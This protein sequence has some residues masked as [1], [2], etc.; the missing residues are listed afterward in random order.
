VTDSIPDA[1]ALETWHGIASRWPGETHS[2]HAISGTTTIATSGGDLAPSPIASLSKLLSSY[3]ILIGVEEGAVH[4]DDRIGPD[5]STLRHLLAHCS[6]Y[7]PDDDRQ[8]APPGT[9]RIY[10]NHGIE[11][12]ADHL[13][14]SSG[15]P[16]ADYVTEAVLTPLQMNATIPSGS[17]A[18]G[19]RSTGTDLVLFAT[20]LMNPTLIAPGT[21]AEATSAQFGEIGGVL[22]GF[23]SQQPNDWG[24]GFEIRGHKS[25]HWTGARNHPAT[26]GH[27]GR[28]GSLLWID[29][30]SRVGL[31]GVGIVDFDA[32]AIE[33]WPVL[34]D[35]TLALVG[36]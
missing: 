7:A 25:P 15:L 18:H 23:G 5:G 21:L 12:A 3:A 2:V 30:V 28:R 13:A 17:P 8:L 33:L 1:T 32:W 16:F 26:F 24:L 35:A 34:S 19:M 9:K 6:G 27:F 10:S 20:E 4:L 36:R 14:T 11:V 29:P 22:P 31:V